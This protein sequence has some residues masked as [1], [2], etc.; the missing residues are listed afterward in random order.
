MISTEPSSPDEP[1]SGELGLSNSSLQEFSLYIL[2]HILSQD[3]FAK[4]TSNLPAAVTS[5]KI[6]VARI[7][8][9][10]P[11]LPDLGA[12]DIARLKKFENLT[13]LHLEEI[14]VDG[15]GVKELLQLP[16]VFRLTFSCE[17]SKNK[18]PPSTANALTGSD[19]A[20]LRKV[21]H[22][23]NNALNHLTLIFDKDPESTHLWPLF[24]TDSLPQLTIDCKSSTDINTLIAL[25][26]SDSLQQVEIISAQRIHVQATEVTSKLP[27]LKFVDVSK[28]N[29]LHIKAPVGPGQAVFLKVGGKL[30]DVVHG[31]KSL[32]GVKV[33]SSTSSSSDETDELDD[34]D[35]T[36]EEED[37]DEDEDYSDE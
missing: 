37:D 1:F 11:A 9:Q 5:F 29:L 3:L 10:R 13:T 24:V 20:E 14:A 28:C 21:K 16:K 2:P 19:I 31:R 22:P 27:Q 12:Q 35:E 26:S 34:F 4:I 17:V 33:T 8:P 25:L 18:K 32:L 36:G 6:S 7:Q 23:L 30:V 15:D